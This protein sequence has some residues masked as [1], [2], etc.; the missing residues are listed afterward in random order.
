MPEVAGNA[1][2]MVDPFN[3]DSIS[4][5][6]EA[7]YNKEELRQELIKLGHVQKQKFSW[8]RTAELLWNCIAKA[9]T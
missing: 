9:M 8:K 3:V 2:Y 5:G 6:M 7:L 1:A 4:A